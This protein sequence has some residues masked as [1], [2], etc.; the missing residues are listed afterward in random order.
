[1]LLKRC[2]EWPQWRASTPVDKPHGHRGRGWPKNS[3]KV[4]SRWR[5]ED[6]STGVRADSGWRKLTWGGHTDSKKMRWQHCRASTPVDSSWPQRKRTAKEHV[7][8]RSGEGDVD[9]TNTAGVRW[10]RRQHRTA[11]KMERSCLWSKYKESDDKAQV[12]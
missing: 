3:G 10:R 9:S 12:K 7:E 1:M 4:I 2:D 6:T 8:K 5:C 11:L